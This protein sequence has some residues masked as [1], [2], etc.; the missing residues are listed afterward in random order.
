MD[1]LPCVDILAIGAHPDDVELGVGGTMLRLLEQG[2]RVGIL[3]L[4]RGEKGSRGTVQERTSEA[5]EAAVRLGV[6]TRA[7][8]GLPDGGLENTMEQRA[9]IAPFIRAMRPMRILTHM[10]T[11]RHPDHHVAHDLVRDANF[12]AGVASLD[13]GHEPH[14]AALLHYFHPYYEDARPPQMVIDISDYMDRKLHALKAHA[15]QFYNPSYP[16]RPTFVSSPEF[17][18]GIRT[19]AA[20][21]GGRIGVAYGEPLFAD[22]PIGLGSLPGLGEKS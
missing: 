14:R 10:N 4:T 1:A 6:T 21:W 18:E 12:L 22:G 13:T 8:A 2:H 11:D 15:S 20:Y 16:G 3:D 17:W 7:N 9:A 19:R 5:A